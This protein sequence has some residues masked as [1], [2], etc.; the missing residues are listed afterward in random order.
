[1]LAI[2]IGRRT[3]SGT[4][5][6]K[7][8]GAIIFRQPVTALV[9]ECV[10]HQRMKREAG[11]ALESRRVRI[12]LGPTPK[13]TA[14]PAAIMFGWGLLPPPTPAASL[15]LASVASGS[16]RRRVRLPAICS[17]VVSLASIMQTLTQVAIL[18]IRLMGCGLTMGR[19]GGAMRCIITG[20][21]NRLIMAVGVVMED[22]IF[23]GDLLEHV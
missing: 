21:A 23:I 1:V 22:T 6:A 16:A 14:A 3:G 15:M 18:S 5:G 19:Y 12:G 4:M 13:A 7:V 2:A 17:M 8:A 11:Q 9:R 20:E 10:S